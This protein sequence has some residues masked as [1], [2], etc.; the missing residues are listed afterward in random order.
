MVEDDL[1]SRKALGAIL[2]RQGWEVLTAANLAEA[3]PIIETRPDVLILDLMLPD[4]DGASLLRQIR[5]Q[6]SKTR[7]VVTTGTS[8]SARLARVYQL[9]P[10]AVLFKP[11][12]L[13]MLI[14]AIELPR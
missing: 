6:D 5:E 10:D 14:K 9:K 7:V 3:H 8:D 2:S 11:I 1:A 13:G 12:D 4:G